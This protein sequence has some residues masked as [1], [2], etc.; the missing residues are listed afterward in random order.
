VAGLAMQLAYEVKGALGVGRALH[1]NAHEVVDL[2]CVAD[3]LSHQ[4]ESQILVYIEAHVGEFQADVGIKFAR[5][6]LL[7]HLVIELGALLGF[8]DVGDVLAQ[9]VD[10]DTGAPPVDCLGDADGVGELSSGDK[11]AGEA[12]TEGRGLGEV[13]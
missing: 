3:Q 13:T 10:A 8:V 5:R 9:V 4:R 1:V 6:H 2:H 7:E 11:A 12:Q